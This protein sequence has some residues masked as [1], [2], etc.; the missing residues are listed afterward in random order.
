MRGIDDLSVNNIPLSNILFLF[1]NVSTEGV[2]GRKGVSELHEQAGV[3][4][5]HNYFILH[6]VWDADLSLGLHNAMQH[7]QPFKYSR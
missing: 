5:V 7:G 2:N 3:Q 6:V 1:F 4:G